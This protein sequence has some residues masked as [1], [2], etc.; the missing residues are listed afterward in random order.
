MP[1]QFQPIQVIDT[2]KGPKFDMDFNKSRLGKEG[3]DVVN[4]EFILD[5][6]KTAIKEMLDKFWKSADKEHRPWY[7]FSS[8]KKFKATLEMYANNV[9]KLLQTFVSRIKD[10]QAKNPQLVDAMAGSNIDRINGIVNK[11]GP[12]FNYE[13]LL[14]M[15]NSIDNIVRD[16]SKLERDLDGTTRDE[17]I[18]KR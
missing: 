1:E 8:E 4:L 12:H 9:N 2:G 14:A 16:K 7:W 10:I 18:A 11:M 3:Q 13:V 17:Q 5:S 15:N 6:K